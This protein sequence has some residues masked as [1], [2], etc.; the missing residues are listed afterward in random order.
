M[1]VQTAVDS[2]PLTWGYV[3]TALAFTATLASV[4]LLPVFFD[5]AHHRRAVARRRAHRAKGRQ[6]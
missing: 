1:S 2:A 6:P 3:L 5:S 4:L